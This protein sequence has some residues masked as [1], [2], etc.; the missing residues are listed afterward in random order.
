MNWDTLWNGGPSLTPLEIFLRVTIL[1]FSIVVMTRLM[2]PR[3][4]GIVSAFNF[5]THAGMAHVATSRMVNPESS[6]TAALVIIAV[7]YSLSLLL[8]MI[9]YRFPSW[10]GT[11]PV[12]LVQNGQI[13]QKNLKRAQVTMD[14]L[15]AQLRLKKVHNLSDVAAAVLEPMGELS[16]IK[17]PESSPITR[18]MLKLPDTPTGMGTVLIYDGKVERQHLYALGL[19][20]HWLKKEI[21]KKGFSVSQVL[22][23]TLEST[24][25]IHVS[26][27]NNLN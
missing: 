20:E 11:S 26:V 18:S 8:S 24:G 4:V 21:A 9:D 2:G 15:L 12:P 7:A 19:K 1:Y 25:N 23:A 16:V 3:Q 13:L 5:I 27:Q 6:L 17:T 22:L 14:D 10:V